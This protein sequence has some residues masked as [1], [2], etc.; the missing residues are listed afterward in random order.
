AS[1]TLLSN[2]G[3]AYF[4]GTATTSIGSDGIINIVNG[5]SVTT[6]IFAELGADNNAWATGHGALQFYDGTASTFLVGALTSDAPSNGQVPKWNTDG[7]ITWEADNNSGGATAWDAIADPSTATGIGMAELA[8]T[9]D[10]NTAATTLAS[11]DG[12]TL[13]LTNDAATDVFN[14]RLLVLTNEDAGG[15]ALATEALLAIDNKDTTEAVTDGIIIT[16]AAGGITDAIDVSDTSGITNALNIGPNTI[17]GTTGVI[18]FTSFDVDGSGNIAG[19]TLDTGQGANELYDMDQNVLTTSNVTFVNASTTLLSALGTIYVGSTATTTI[20][21]SAINIPT[22]GAYQINSTSVL[23]GTTLGSGVTASSLTSVGA[24]GSG[25]ISSGFGAI[26]IGSDALTAGAGSLSS[27]S[28]TGDLTFTHLV[29]SS[30]TLSIADASPGSDEDGTHLAIDAGS[31]GT[32]DG[33]GGDVVINPGSKASGG[34]GIDGDILLATT[35]GGNVGIATTAPYAKL[36]VVGQVVGAYFTATTTAPSTFINASTT[37]ITTSSLEFTESDANP[38]CSSGNYTVYADT[39]EGKLKKCENGTASD[40]DGNLND[41]DYFTATGANTWTRPANVSDVYVEVWGG[42]GAGADAAGNSSSAGGGGAGYGSALTGV[43]GNETATVGAAATDSTF[44]TDGT[45]VTAKGGTAGSGTTGGAGGVAGTGG[46]INLAG[47]SASNSGSTAAGTGGGGSPRGGAGGVGGGGGVSGNI[48]GTAGTVPGGGGGGGHED[49]G[50]GGAG[51]TGMIVVWEV[52]GSV[53]GADLAELYETEADVEIGDVVAVGQRTLDYQ[54]DTLGP[55]SISILKKATAGDELVGVVSSVPSKVMG[56]EIAKHAEHPQPVALS[57]RVPVNVSTAN[58][59]IKRGDLLTASS[60]PGVAMLATKAGQTIGSAL[61]DYNGPAGEIGQVLTLVNTAYSFGARTRRILEQHGVTYTEE[62]WRQPGIDMARLMLADMLGNKDDL[63]AKEEAGIALSE[64]YTDRLAAGL[65]VVAPRVVTET[66]VTNSIEPALGDDI[67]IRLEPDGKLIIGQGDKTTLKTL[68]AEITPV[69]T[70]DYDGNAV[71]AGEI[72]A[73]KVVA[74]NIFGLEVVADKFTQLSG[75]VATLVA[76][77]STAFLDLLSDGLTTANLTV[78]GI[79]TT[80]ELH[81]L[82]IVA[83]EID[84]PTI[85]S[86]LATTSAL[87]DRVLVLEQKELVLPGL[88]MRGDVLALLADTE[89]FGRPYFTTDTA[90]FAL[91]KAGVREV[92]VEFVREYLE[93]PIVNA[94]IS[95]ADDADEVEQLFT[96]DIRFLVIRKSPR[97]FTILLNKAA[98]RDIQFSWTAFAVKGARTFESATAE[99]VPPAPESVLA[100][101][102]LPTPEPE[103]EITSEPEPEVVPEP[104]PLVEEVPLPTE[105]VPVSD[106]EPE[107]PPEPPPVDE[108]GE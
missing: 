105:E 58:G 93:P 38:G 13:T 4:G 57:G 24:L 84:S 68:G 62:E 29:G 3:T 67:G 61:E 75:E 66:L 42:G 43:D 96:D 25:S 94:T 52:T 79:A 35:V 82:K 71:F 70:F 32:I 90:G 80:T 102:S 21:S 106:P 72:R 77:S 41:V 28:L 36:S 31:G 98:R 104:T 18:N 50:T 64:I 56:W 89:F 88:E 63:I 78:T 7:T 37:N 6:D 101:P 99:V 59:T 51:A 48:N 53:S 11:F 5:A 108:S 40:L 1:S 107:L 60:I 54:A 39:S 33:S 97:G 85:T 83:G 10:W 23:S 44:T 16:S 27:L 76:S 81:A 100:P 47:G 46:D 19:I 92:A 73:N 91:I 8:Q 45:T 87:S 49:S 55:E 17:L 14:Q 12:L 74:D 103:P 26:N 95:L 15:V 30:R 9:L 22:G 2:T 69:I 34:A 20:T 86:L 65:E